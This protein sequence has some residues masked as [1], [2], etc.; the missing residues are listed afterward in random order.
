MNGDLDEVIDTLKKYE[1]KEKY[2]DI[3]I[4]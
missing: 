2:K 3:I 1:E 4:E